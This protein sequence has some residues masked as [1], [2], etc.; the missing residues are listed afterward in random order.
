METEMSINRRNYIANL[1]FDKIS[2][3]NH[4]GRPTS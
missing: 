3:W 4:K 2:N 1:N